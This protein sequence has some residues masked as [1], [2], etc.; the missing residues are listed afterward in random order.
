[1]RNLQIKSNIKSDLEIKGQRQGRE[2][3]E[4]CQATGFVRLVIFHQN[5]SPPATYDYTKK[6]PNTCALSVTQQETGMLTKG[7]IKVMHIAL[8]NTS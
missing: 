2:K 7:Q 6:V 4:L 3:R 8:A 5:F 1:M